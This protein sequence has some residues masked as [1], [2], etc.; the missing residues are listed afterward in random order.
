[1]FKRILIMICF[2]SMVGC[3]PQLPQRTDITLDQL[4]VFQSATI[5]DSN[6]GL[7]S[8]GISKVPGTICLIGADGKCAVNGL[9]PRQCLIKGTTVEVKPS[10]NPVPSYHSLV[11]SE[12]KVTAAA[13]FVTPSS[14]VEFLDEIKATI[15]GSA[16][17]SGSSQNNGYPGFDGIKACLL[18][19]YGPG[20]YGK[21]YWIQSANI[22]A[23]TKSHFKQVTSALNV[24]ASGFGMNGNTY[25]HDGFDEERVWIGLQASEIPAVGQVSA[26]VQVPATVVVSPN[27]AT[28]TIVQPNAVPEPAPPASTTSIVP[29][30]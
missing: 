17:I 25:K 24:S 5:I 26:A 16:M 19:I 29:S 20:T 9:A 11:S 1:M 30:K 6:N 12:Y 21:V 23:V 27:P 4:P 14:S 18:D 2:I 7:L 8:D 13:P 28:T 22:L 15:A 10:I 3:A